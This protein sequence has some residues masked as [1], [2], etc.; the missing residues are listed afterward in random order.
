MTLAPLFA[1]AAALLAVAG[2]MKLRSP[3]AASGALAAMSLAAA[4]PAVRTAGAC[5]L[6]L[7]TW[8]LLSPGRLAAALLAAA[9]GG[10]AVFVVGLLRRGGASARGCGCFGEAEAAVHPIHLVLNLAAAGAAAA[11]VIAP[12]EPLLRIVADHPAI[13]AVLCVGLAG[14]V[15]AAYLLYTVAPSAW[16]AYAGGR[17]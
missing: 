4:A 17:A 1:C 12:P 10:F 11:A 7:G 15:Y 8:A 13:G 5:E 3:S 9:Y 6:A 2:L 16:R 14:A